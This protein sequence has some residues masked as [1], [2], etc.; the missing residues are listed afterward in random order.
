[1][2]ATD[3]GVLKQ[4]QDLTL[5][6]TVTNG[7]DTDLAATTADV[8]LSR[9][10]TGDR[11]DLEDWLEDTSSD[12]YLGSYLTS[13]DVPVVPAHHTVTMTDITIPSATVGLD[14]YSFGA[15]RLAV[16]YASGSVDV[17]GRSAI[18]WYPS[19]TQQ[20]TDV[21]VVMPITVPATTSTTLSA[22]ELAADTAVDGTLTAQ[23]DAAIDHNVAI[24][25]DPR[26]IVSI[27]LL[28][29]DA[30]ESAVA[31]LDRLTAARNET[32]ALPYADADLTGL[33]QA[34]APGVFTP[35]SFDQDVDP[36]HFPGAVTPTPT[37]TATGTTDGA[38]G[39]GA[40]AASA[41]PTA[42]AG[43]STSAGGGT[44]TSAGAGTSTG[45]E[46]GTAA[47]TGTTAG[48]DTTPAPGTGQPE[49]EP[50]PA[51]PTLPTM[52]T[53]LDFPYTLPSIAWPDEDTV[54]SDDLP[55]LAKGVTSTPSSRTGTPR[56]A[57]TPRSPPPPRPGPPTSSCPTNG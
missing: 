23:L 33:R 24:G 15:R 6:V 14:G 25:I 5:T 56:P 42:G 30:P 39:A 3:Q 18:T 16:S 54:T 43:P 37:A 20:P 45:G 2:A 8:S 17:V 55:V 34:G 4:D 1:M 11:S 41:T 26:I 35:I 12:G 36:R 51:A 48:T 38:S 32:F 21:S 57:R 19:L 31:W 50:T 53:L 52:Q 47:G 44:G 28:G 13:F 9:S 10:V 22:S 29:Q 49:G 46:T 27:R 40:A 7:T